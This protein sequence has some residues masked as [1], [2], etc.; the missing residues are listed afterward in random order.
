MRGCFAGSNIDCFQSFKL[1]LFRP[2]LTCRVGARPILV[3]K[4]LK[5]FL[6]GRNSHVHSLV[7]LATLLLINQKVSDLAWIQGQFSSSQ[8]KSLIASL[9]QERSIV[10]NHY[11]APRKFFR[12]CS[13]RIW[14]LKSRKLVGSSRSSR[15][16]SCKS[17]A[18]SFTRVCQPP[19]S[20]LTGPS[21]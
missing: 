2:C 9:S 1:F 3:D 8:V 14:V 15:L 19:E 11:D 18:A 20:S 13:S 17:S 4:L 5:L 7:V 16:G 10:G 12:K 21:K 6:L